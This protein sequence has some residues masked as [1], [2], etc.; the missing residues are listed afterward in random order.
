MT[1]AD[2][3]L[4]VSRSSGSG[5]GNKTA[6]IGRPEEPQ[7][8]PQPPFVDRRRLNRIWS[9]NTLALVM[10]LLQLFAHSGGGCG[11]SAAPTHPLA[12]DASNSASLVNPSTKHLQKRS[13]ASSFRLTF[14]QKL[15]AS[16]THLDWENTCHM[17]P[18][19]LNEA[20]SKAK[21]CKKRQKI[22]QKLQN[23]TGRELKAIQ[24]ED[25]ARITINA[26]KLATNNTKTLDIVDKNKW[27]FYKEIYKFL[28]RLNVTSKQLNLRH[29]HRDLQIYVGAFTYMRN[30]KMHW[31]LV[32]HN[33]KSVLSD[34]LDR[35][36]KSAQEVLCSVE[37]AI[38]VTNLLYTPRRSRAQQ[39]RGGKKRRQAQPVVTYKILPRKLMEKRLQQFNSTELPLVELHHNATLAARGVDVLPP[40][41]NLMVLEQHALFTKL[42]FVQYMKGIRKILAKQRRT[43][44]KA[45]AKMTK[46]IPMKL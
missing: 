4:D 17:K 29:A 24:D 37:E 45:T 42:K 14:Q 33:A 39:R 35:M 11:V 2:R 36:R 6:R 1:T 15:I 41:D 12:T 34:E 18:T 43:L 3:P 31:D 21:R 28:P 22:L 44:C 19:G 32:V 5:S 25:R 26:D 7:P 30:I 46:A 40:P 23:Q 13:Q 38:N 10:A 20:H 8:Q 27:R 16:S 9:L